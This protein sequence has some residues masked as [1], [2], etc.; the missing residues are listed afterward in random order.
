MPQLRCRPGNRLGSTA[1]SGSVSVGLPVGL[2]RPPPLCVARLWRKGL[3]RTGNLLDQRGGGEPRR[4]C[5]LGACR[6][7]SRRS[8]ARP[9]VAGGGIHPCDGS[10]LGAVRLCAWRKP[11]CTEQDCTGW[12]S[13]RGGRRGR[14]RRRP[15]WWN[16]GV[17]SGEGR[18]LCAMATLV[19][20]SPF[21][22][23]C[24]GAALLSPARCCVAST[25]LDVNTKQ[26]GAAGLVPLAQSFLCCAFRA[27]IRTVNFKGKA[28]CA[29][30]PRVCRCQNL[31]LRREERE[32]P[33]W[34]RG[35]GW[36]YAVHAGQPSE[37]RCG[38]ALRARV[39]ARGWLPAVHASGPGPD[40]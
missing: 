36:V 31:G 32:G 13:R 35:W 34:G 1:D 39:H 23:A 2:H 24:A 17:E 3:G 28:A 40:R 29:T 9:V 15:R 25:Q 33:P 11:H 4:N 26:C 19:Y 22:R 16:A 27:A 30:A 14:S 21:T 7:L 18:P 20:C 38:V 37:E 12:P 8:V 6:S 10:L 5:C